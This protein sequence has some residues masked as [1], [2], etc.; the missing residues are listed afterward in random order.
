MQNPR[1]PGREAE[2]GGPA[3]SLV[4]DQERARVLAEPYRGTDASTSGTETPGNN[5]SHGVAT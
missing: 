4:R 1:A 3:H 2:D 5:R